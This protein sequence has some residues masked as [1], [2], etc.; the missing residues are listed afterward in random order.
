M[1]RALCFCLPTWSRAL[2][3]AV[4]YESRSTAPI[5]RIPDELVVE[6]VDAADYPAELTVSH[7]CR[8]LRQTV[9]NA[10]TLWTDVVVN[11]NRDGSVE[12]SKLYIERSAPRQIRLTLNAVSDLQPQSLRVLT[13]NCVDRIVELYIQFQSCQAVETIMHALRGVAVPSLEYLSIKSACKGYNNDP[14]VDLSGLDAPSIVS[15]RLDRCIFGRN[16]PPWMRTSLTDL[17]LIDSV[18]LHDTNSWAFLFGPSSPPL[19]SLTSLYLDWSI[20]VNYYS[21]R[22][23]RVIHSTSLTHLSL[24]FYSDHENAVLNALTALHLPALTHLIIHGSHGDNISAICNSGSVSLGVNIPSLTSLTLANIYACGKDL[25]C[26]EDREYKPITRRPLPHIFSSLST[27]TLIKQ[28]FTADILRELFGP[29]SQS[30]F[31]RLERIEVWPLYVEIDSVYEALQGLVRNWNS[32]RVPVLVMPPHLCQREGW[33]EDQVE[34][35]WNLEEYR[36][37]DSDE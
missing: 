23:D 34:L 18:A 3:F 10:S 1:T 12:I 35:W 32:E 15:L 27:L 8:S 7:V 36:V 26:S 17:T 16:I 33:K 4:V 20:G 19:Q 37:K 21:D 14:V 30:C 13:P 11:V 5:L 6:I 2:C 25:E 28:C 24:E 29:N 22:L 31:G 9:V